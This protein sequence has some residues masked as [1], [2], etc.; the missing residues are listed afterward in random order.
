MIGI[1]EPTS[2]LED[3]DQ[4]QVPHQGPLPP[5]PVSEETEDQRAERS[6]EKSEGDGCGDMLRVDVEL[7]AKAGGGE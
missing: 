6:E 1:T 4:A 2:H 3:A 5:V 7:L